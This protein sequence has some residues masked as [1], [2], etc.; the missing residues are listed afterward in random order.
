MNASNAGPR[1]YAEFWPFYLGEHRRRGTRALH[2]AGTVAGLGLVAVAAATADWRWL[3][4]ALIAGYGPAWIGHATIEHN[5]PATFAH[6]LWSLYS[7]LRMLGLFATGRLA[8][9]LKRNGV[10]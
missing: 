4:A 10:S 1:S 7:D 5:R 3:P 9:E 2:L 8:A 6:P